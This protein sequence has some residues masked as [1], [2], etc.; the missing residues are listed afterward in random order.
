MERVTSLQIIL[1]LAKLVPI[2]MQI[3]RNLTALCMVSGTK[4]RPLPSVKT[5][6]LPV[7][8]LTPKVMRSVETTW[9]R[10]PQPSLGLGDT[11]RRSDS[12]EERLNGSRLLSPS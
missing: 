7:V 1:T 12:I 3:E 8:F 11:Q 4:A 2:E 6:H 9:P 5:F 10:S